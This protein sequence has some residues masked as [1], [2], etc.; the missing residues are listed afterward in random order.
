MKKTFAWFSAVSTVLLLTAAC[1]NEQTL[2]KGKF[3]DLNRARQDLETAI[4]AGK[5]CDAAE[6]VLQRLSLGTTALQG[7]IAS[8]AERDL[9]SAYSHL[10]AV[11]R[12]GLLLC[13]SRSLLSGFPF[14]PQ[15][16][17]Y[18]SQELDPVVERYDLPTEKHLYAPTGKYWKSVS[19]DSLSVVWESAEAEI[20]HI[21][22]MM[23][24]SE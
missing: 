5:A 9:L 18:V 17:I 3:A 11:S 23:K 7:R 1:M 20:R 21:E 12:D 16:R 24:Y 22:T 6:S 14:V 19:A 8:K 4:R 15:G 13:R 10:T 2:D